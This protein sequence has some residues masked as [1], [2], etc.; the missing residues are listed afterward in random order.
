M[1]HR[2]S[3]YQWQFSS[4]LAGAAALIVWGGCQQANSVSA[5]ASS[6]PAAAPA[7]AAAA[8]PGA[9]N[10]VAVAQFHKAVEPILQARCYECHGDGAK[11][12]GIAFDELTPAK[13]A[14]DPQLWLKV[15]KNTRSQI[16][17]PLDADNPL[18]VTE[19]ETLEGWIKT[20]AFGLDP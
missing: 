13:I 19:R 3:R 15:L 9:E 6:G 14:G 2:L 17:P 11:K 1:S 5:E 18:T 20:A 10:P 8:Q 12:G 4:M 16:M 7:A